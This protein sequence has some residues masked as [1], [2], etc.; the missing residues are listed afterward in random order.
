[1]IYIRL[2]QA[3]N[4]EIEDK[5]SWNQAG[6][7]RIQAGEAWKFRKNSEIFARIA[8]FITIIAKFSLCIE[9]SLHSKIFTCSEMFLL[10]VFV[11]KRTHFFFHLYS[12]CNDTINDKLVFSPFVRLYK[13]SY[14]QFIT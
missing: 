4:E 7:C 3:G 6:I 9:I 1:M 8:K 13:P 14:E 10:R 12:H 5:T 2:H 11:Y